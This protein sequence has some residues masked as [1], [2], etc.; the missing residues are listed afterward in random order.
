MSALDAATHEPFRVL[1]LAS[2][3]MEQDFLSLP[4]YVALPIA[5]ELAVVEGSYAG[6][7]LTLRAHAFAAQGV[8]VGRVARIDG[9]GSWILNA[10]VFPDERHSTPILGIELLVF[11]ER[12]HLIVADLFPLRDAD[13]GVMDDLGPLFD[14]VG[15][16]P[17]M[18]R[19]AT[20]IFSRR[21]VFRKPKSNA[22][23]SEG[24]RAVRLVSERWTAMAR[25][26]TPE[27]PDAAAASRARRDDYVT[28]HA[29]DEP[30]NPFL[31][32][33]FGA[34]IG[35]RLVDEVLFPAA[36]FR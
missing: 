13:A 27:R 29:E 32:K 26:A 36:A 4:G 10:V 2:A 17:E 24:A 9:P 8:R 12:M 22:M 35:K 3:A 25:A 1:D 34:E 20:R 14:E 5:P 15:D 33:A 16:E 18:P 21:P 28:A 7:K 30:A 11:R 6:K 23:L 19:W 31:G